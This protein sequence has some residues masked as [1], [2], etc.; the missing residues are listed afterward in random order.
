M[1]YFVFFVFLSL[2]LF[3]Q[4]AKSPEP[5]PQPIELW[6]SV[7]EVRDEGLV[8]YPKTN[9]NRF[10]LVGLSAAEADKKDGV[11]LVWAVA[12]GTYSYVDFRGEKQTLPQY[13][14]KEYSKNQYV[15]PPMLR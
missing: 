10:F 3:A 15:S 4:P 8:V 14:F 11:I 12:D 5:T 9:R 1:R 6:G 13:R 7:I 2:S